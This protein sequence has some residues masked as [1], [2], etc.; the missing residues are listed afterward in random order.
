MLQRIVWVLAIDNISKIPDWLA[1]AFSRLATGGGLS[2]R[3]LYSDT[4]ETHLDATRPII[5]NGIEDLATSGDLLDRAIIV[6]LPKISP[7]ERKLEQTLWSQFEATR[8]KILGAL[9]LA[10]AHS[11]Y[12]ADRI[13]R[14]QYPR[15]ADFAH[16]S[17]ATAS[18]LPWE[19]WQ[20]I[21]AYEA[22][23]SGANAICHDA[24]SVAGVI[25]ALI[26]TTPQREGTASDLL[27]TLN[28][29]AEEEKTSDIYWPSAPNCLAN[30]LRRIAPVLRRV[31]IDVEIDIRS[32]PKR[33]I[34]SNASRN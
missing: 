25:Q 30:R 32:R 22:N 5:L 14:R 1:D 33:V 4:D 2:T 3:Q 11:L 7:S 12:Y 18:G 6:N 24:D 8:P 13:Q 10:V 28:D 29:L 19:N 23:I 21:N 26:E 34:I 31:G 15:M 27:K 16:W 9:L 17:V 20:L